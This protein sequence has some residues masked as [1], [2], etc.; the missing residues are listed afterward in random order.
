MLFCEETLYVLVDFLVK[1]LRR[2]HE[3]DLQ[4]YL[5]T[6]IRY[7]LQRLIFFAIE[8]FKLILPLN[9]SSA[10]FEYSRL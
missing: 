5:T 7:C 3:K 4:L 8:V 2:K 1:M 6:E 9:R 10:C